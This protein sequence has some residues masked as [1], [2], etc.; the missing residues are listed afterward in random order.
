MTLKSW[1]HQTETEGEA[2]EQHG[3]DAARITS[4]TRKLVRT[5]SI[6][7]EY[8]AEY[9][10]LF[11][12]TFFERDRTFLPLIRYTRSDNNYRKYWTCSVGSRAVAAW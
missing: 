8:V 7:H 6:L 10:Q 11:E 2:E 9:D 1:I 12:Q 5:L 3:D 4:E